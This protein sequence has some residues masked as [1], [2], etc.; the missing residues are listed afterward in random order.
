MQVAF[1][2]RPRNVL[3]WMK[4]GLDRPK[5]WMSWGTTS[6]NRDLLSHGPDPGSPG[7]WWLSTCDL[8]ISSG[9]PVFSAKDLPVAGRKPVEGGA[10]SPGDFQERQ[11]ASLLTSSCLLG[12]LAEELSSS[13]WITL[14]SPPASRFGCLVCGLCSDRPV[15]AFGA[16]LLTRRSALPLTGPPLHACS[17][18]RGLF[19]AC[20]S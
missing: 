16:S 5:L 20:R 6:V 14:L 19:G 12:Q 15:I 4:A 3:P 9:V 7:I 11:H 13:P 17:S 1:S 8:L 2:R 18:A 10:F